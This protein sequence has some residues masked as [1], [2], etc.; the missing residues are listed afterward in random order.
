MLI[1]RLRSDDEAV[2][3]ERG[4]RFAAPERVDHSVIALQL[5]LAA[6]A[7]SSF[8]PCL[9]SS[10]ERLAWIVHI[11]VTESEE[12]DVSFSDPEI[13]FSIFVSVPNRSSANSNLRISEALVHETMHLQLSLFE[14]LIPLI[15][16][17][18]PPETFFSPWKNEYRDLVGLLHGAYVFRI[19]HEMWSAAEQK[20]TDEATAAFAARRCTTILSELGQVRAIAKRRGLT[21][22]GR[23]FVS[24]LLL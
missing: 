13:P 14:R 15:D 6:E 20:A 21:Q 2:F 17:S 11:L 16:S 4:L 8:L 18:Q 22:A 5:G 1:E 7:A 9:R 24:R 23:E 19:L 12:Y 3:I 10:I